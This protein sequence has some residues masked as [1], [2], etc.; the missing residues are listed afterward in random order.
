MASPS[1]SNSI[2][3]IDYFTHILPHICWSTLV[4]MV[5]WPSFA[6]SLVQQEIRRR[7]VCVIARFMP[8]DTVVPLF[9]RLD[10]CDGIIV[11]AAVRQIL[12]LHMLTDAEWDMRLTLDL[13]VP[14]SGRDGIYNF[15]LDMGYSPIPS[16]KPCQ[17]HRK[18]VREVRRLVRRV[19]DK[20]WPLSARCRA[21][22]DPLLGRFRG[23]LDQ[24]AQGDRRGPQGDL[25]R[26]HERSDLSRARLLLS[27]LD[28]L[29]EESDRRRVCGRSM[30]RFFGRL[31]TLKSNELRLG[32]K[33][34]SV[35]PHGL[36]ENVL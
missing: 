29:K 26:G 23:R 4:S 14:P 22:T 15:L 12:L 35:L 27:G 11:G 19:D 5:L 24:Q 10:E 3:H 25:H 16:A 6:P 9:D 20:V 2:Y 21:C 13:A 18:T 8:T 7:V 34:W 32:S 33:L 28:S 1:V 31:D 17:Y 36:E 30:L